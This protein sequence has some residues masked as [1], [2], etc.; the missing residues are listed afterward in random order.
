[1]MSEEQAYKAMFRFL[2]KYYE[3]TQADDIGALLG[4]MN[5]KLFKDGRPADAA[6]WEEWQLAI[7]E[8]LA[9]QH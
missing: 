2:E 9:A 3:L 5:M 8:V 6:M 7:R 1:M 4:S